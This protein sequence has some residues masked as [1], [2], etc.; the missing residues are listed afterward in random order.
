MP[1]FW[2]SE[3]LAMG[4]LL[5]KHA[6]NIDFSKS[7]P[8]YSISR[9]W[10]IIS[11]CIPAAM[12]SSCTVVRLLPRTMWLK[13]ATLAGGCHGSTYAWTVFILCFPLP[14][15][16]QYTQW[17][18]LIHAVPVTLTTVEFVWVMPQTA[19]WNVQYI[20]AAVCLE[21]LV[22]TRWTG[23][24]FNWKRQCKEQWAAVSR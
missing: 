9:K 1:I 22:W 4:V 6:V 15:D 10:A 5:K 2:G 18:Q 8:H 13:V 7:F 16:P 20:D 12:P 17:I 11:N 21:P 14:N 19:V 24:S 23:S 3:H